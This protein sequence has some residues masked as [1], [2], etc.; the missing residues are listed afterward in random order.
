MKDNPKK[1]KFKQLCNRFKRIKVAQSLPKLLVNLL[2]TSRTKNSLLI[3]KK[4]QA[5]LKNQ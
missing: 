4:I 5:I 2:N 1:K 3:L